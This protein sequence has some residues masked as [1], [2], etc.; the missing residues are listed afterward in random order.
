MKKIHVHNSQKDLPISLKG[1]RAL[2]KAVLEHF[3][4]PHTEASIY[5]VTTKKICQLHEE[6]FDDP[7]TTDCISFP[8]DEEH[9]GEVFVCPKTAI[10]YATTKGI[11]PFDETAL[12]VIHGLLHCLGY[13]DLEPKAKRTMRKKEKNCMALI[14]KL[15][16]YLQP[17]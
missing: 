13:D 15:N 10:D 6:F 8:L 9:L 5:F 16:I 2:V 4:A 11:D 14:K 1:V 7:T 3:K 17:L 12:Y